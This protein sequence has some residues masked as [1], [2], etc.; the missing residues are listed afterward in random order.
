MEAVTRLNSD[1]QYQLY[2]E[3]LLWFNY[4]NDKV[5]KMIFNAKQWSIKKG[6]KKYGDKGKK[7][8]LKEI[9]N[10][11]VKNNYFGETNYNKLTQEMKDKALPILMFMILKQNGEL[12]TRGVANGSYQYIYTNKD[13]CTSPTPDF[14]SFKYVCTVIAKEGRDVATVD[15]PGFFLQMEQDELILLKIT[16]SVTL[17]LVELDWDKWHK[18]LRKENQR[19]VIYV[20]CNKAIYSTMNASLLAYKKLATLY[21]DWG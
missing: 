16:G 9:R 12:K 19:W 11:T 15:L 2:V 13:D 1:E 5:S 14:Y 6:I 10:L 4:T 20:V 21:K 17:L 3:A 8:A 7:S 18:H